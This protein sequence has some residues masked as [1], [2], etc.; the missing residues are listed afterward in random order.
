MQFFLF[1]HHLPINKSHDLFEKEKTFWNK[2]LSN[3]ERNLSDMK[4]QF[5][6]VINSFTLNISDNLLPDSLLQLEVVPK[7][8]EKATKKNQNSFASDFSEVDN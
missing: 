1:Q 3:R 2:H 4:E 6:D 7:K 8:E 5:I